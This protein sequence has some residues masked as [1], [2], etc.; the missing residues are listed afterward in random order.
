MAQ[1]AAIPDGPEFEPTLVSTCLFAHLRYSEL[2]GEPCE[3]L[4]DQAVRVTI[5]DCYWLIDLRLCFWVGPLVDVQLCCGG[6][7]G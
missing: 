3:A 6:T 5:G 7:D 2:G 4:R 1:L